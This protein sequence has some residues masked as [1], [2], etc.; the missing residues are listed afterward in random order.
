MAAT[1]TVRLTGNLSVRAGRML[2]T[3]SPDRIRKGLACYSVRERLYWYMSV[4]LI[5]GPRV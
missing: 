1:L 3:V 2:R 5:V 4:D